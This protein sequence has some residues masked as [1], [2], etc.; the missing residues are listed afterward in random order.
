VSHNQLS[1]LPKCLDALTKLEA[2]VGA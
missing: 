2:T 1:A